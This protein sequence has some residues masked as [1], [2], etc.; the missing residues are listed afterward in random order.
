MRLCGR[1]HTPRV[2]ARPACLSMQLQASFLPFSVMPQIAKGWRRYFFD[3]GPVGHRYRSFSRHAWVVCDTLCSCLHSH[4]RVCE[5]AHQKLTTQ[6]SRRQ[7]FL[8]EMAAMISLPSFT[9]RLGLRVATGQVAGDA[10]EAAEDMFASPAELEGGAVDGGTA[11]GGAGAGAQRGLDA[12]APLP[13]DLVC[14][15]VWWPVQQARVFFCLAVLEV[16]LLLS[17]C[18][19]GFVV[20][21]FC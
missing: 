1:E 18:L 9:P 11:A 10:V 12:A 8:L 19:C 4:W 20:V 7:E 6:Q 15:G 21:D 16:V 5:P 14:N 13:V 2:L 3:R 17:S